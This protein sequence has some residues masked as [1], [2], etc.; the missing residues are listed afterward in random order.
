MPWV[1][2]GHTDR[3]AEPE[4]T[5]Q[6]G[7]VAGVALPIVSSTRSLRRVA[8][9]GA[10][11]MAVLGS[12]LTGT[13][14]AKTNVYT[15][16][17]TADGGTPPIVLAKSWL[18]ADADTGEVL[19]AKNPHEHLRPASTLKTL[20]AITLLPILNKQDIYKVTWEDAAAIGSAVGIVPG[21]TYTI[22][23][24]FYGMLLPS[25]NDAAKALADAAGGHRKTVNMMM[26]KA[27][28]LGAND[29]TVRN[30]TGLDA[31]DQYTSAFDLAV[32]AH[33]GLQREDF[34][35]YVSTTDTSFPA[36]MPKK[37]KR[38]Q[39][40]MIY[41]QNPLLM[42][43]FRGTIG[44]KT[45]YTTLA[46]ATYVGAVE[47]GGH[48]YIVTLMSLAEPTEGAAERLFDWTFKHAHELSPLE[49]L[50]PATPKPAAKKTV[51][52]AV[53]PAP[54]TTSGASTG[55]GVSWL[56]LSLISLCLLT[57]AAFIA[58][59]RRRQRRP[60]LPPL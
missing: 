30:P 46:G 2:A 45:G 14:A 35:Q 47:R 11:G 17:G 36:E 33:A 60:S 37:D 23:Q 53:D 16:P 38:R 15:E 54:V 42:N 31:K 57:A 59:R 3:L 24:L 34:R 1:K 9:A 12:S 39:S 19:A 50:I 55:R 52:A 48:T 22:D 4:I 27:K 25:G 58:A 28:E 20:T 51:V 18:V 32:F 7:V 29:T 10:L 43:G 5:L 6:S 21:A 40:Y 8:I 56:A 49:N 41:N 13:A 44:V 26:A